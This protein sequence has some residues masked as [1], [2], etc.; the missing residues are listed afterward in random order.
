M[1]YKIGYAPGWTAYV[2]GIETE[3][4]P[5]HSGL[6]SFA[7]TET[8]DHEIILQYKTPWLKEGL[9]LS[10]ISLLIF[11]SLL[12]TYILINRHKRKLNNELNE[13]K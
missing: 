11:T 12:T 6:I 13:K 7:L 1:N 5:G 8:K 2:D 9:I 10:G 4:F 3:I